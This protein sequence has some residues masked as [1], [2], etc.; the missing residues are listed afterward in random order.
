[1]KS[2]KY[3]LHKKLKTEVTVDPPVNRIIISTMLRQV[4]FVIIHYYIVPATI[5]KAHGESH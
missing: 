1:M 5:S 2:L 4:Q 3:K